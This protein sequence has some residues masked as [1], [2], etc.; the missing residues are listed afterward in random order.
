MAV[1]VVFVLRFAFVWAA[2]AP[3]DTG[4]DPGAGP[5]TGQAR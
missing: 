4:A 2:Y 3:P 1:L 5:D